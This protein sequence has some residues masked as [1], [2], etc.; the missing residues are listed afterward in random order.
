MKAVKKKFSQMT[1]N[2]LQPLPNTKT[3][4]LGQLFNQ[5]KPSGGLPK[6]SEQHLK[7]EESKSQP[8]HWTMSSS[9]VTRVTSK[10]QIRP[11]MYIANESGQEKVF[12]NDQKWTPATAKHQN[13]AFETTFQST[14]TI[15]G[16]S[17][18]VWVQIRKIQDLTKLNYNSFHCY[19]THL[20]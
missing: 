12:T 2:E 17:K 15:R 5:A 3:K 11:H 19:P 7:N 16:P 9:T 1:K 10:S 13:E 4:H 18:G 8:H 14:K 20:N 6:V